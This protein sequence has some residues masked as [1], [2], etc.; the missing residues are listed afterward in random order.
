MAAESKI[1]KEVDYVLVGFF[2]RR[3][4]VVSKLKPYFSSSHLGGLLS[5]VLGLE[6][7]AEVNKSLD[8]LNWHGIVDGGA[9]ATD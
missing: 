1:S 4:N 3:V 6:L 8:S 5:W 2:H 9:D 7:L